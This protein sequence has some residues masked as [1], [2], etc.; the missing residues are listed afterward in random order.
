MADGV[1]GDQKTQHEVRDGGVVKGSYSVVEPDGSIRIVDYA[2]DDVNGFNAVVKKIG[3]AHHV[4][5]IAP[6]PAGH[7]YGGYAGH[8][9]HSHY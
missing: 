3:P 9:L 5:P 1:T 8:G 2:A 4:A 7:G 6:V